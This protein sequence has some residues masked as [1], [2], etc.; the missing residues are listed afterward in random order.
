MNDTMTKDEFNVW[1]DDVTKRLNILKASSVETRLNKDDIL[2]DFFKTIQ[3]AEKSIQT[4]EQGEIGNRLFSVSQIPI[5]SWFHIKETNELFQAIRY[6]NLTHE[7]VCIKDPFN[8]ELFHIN[9][10]LKAYYIG[11]EKKFYSLWSDLLVDFIEEPKNNNTGRTIIKMN[12]DAIIDIPIKYVKKQETL[13]SE[14][15]VTLSS[16]SPVTLSSE[17]PVTLSSESPVTLSSESPEWHPNNQ[18]PI[19]C[20]DCREEYPEDHDGEG[21]VNEKW[22]CCECWDIHF[23]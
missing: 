12:N 10:T 22:Y 19:K 1:L 11:K 9:P 4:L 8:Y 21:F 17:S 20:I 13:S 3:D 23:F 18:W 14:S 5:G 15:P 6:D 7:M 16:E 2:I